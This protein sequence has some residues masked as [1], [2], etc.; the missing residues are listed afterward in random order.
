MKTNLKRLSL[1]ITMTLTIFYSCDKKPEFVQELALPEFT[2]ISMPDS[3]IVKS[4]ELDMKGVIMLKYFSPDCD[5]CQDEARAYLSKV[6]EFSNVKT[7]W[8]C[9]DW[10]SLQQIENFTNTYGLYRTRP[11]GIGKN[12]KS[13]LIPYYKIDGVPYTAIYKDNQLIQVY[14]NGIDYKELKTINDGSFVP[15]PKDTLLKFIQP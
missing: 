1:I 14:Q 3:T 7:L 8:M 9:G 13:S 4:S 6:E 11:I 15:Q 5:H 12:D 10:A 2:L